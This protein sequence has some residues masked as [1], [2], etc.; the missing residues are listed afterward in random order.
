[1][2]AA[3]AVGVG[4]AAAAFFVSTL[5]TDQSYVDYLLITYREEPV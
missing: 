2:V 5:D 1:M 4:V 3:L